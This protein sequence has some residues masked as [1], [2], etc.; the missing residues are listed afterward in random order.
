MG[1]LALVGVMLCAG[2]VSLPCLAADGI[3]SMGMNLAGPADWNTELPFVDVFR[4]SRPWISQHQGKSWGQGPK[5]DMDEH[6]WVKRLDPGCWAE[7][8]LCTIDGGHYPGG[9][10][11]VLY[12]GKGKLDFWGAARAVQSEPGRSAIDVDSSKGAIFLRLMETDAS[13]YVRNIRVIM[14]GFEETYKAN[15]WHPAF[16]KR[17][18]GM[19]CL[20]FMDFMHTNGSKISTWAERPTPSDA[21]FS[22]KGVALEW[23]IDLSNR[24]KADPW[25]CMPH[26]ADDDFVLNFAAMV[27]KDLDPDLKVYVEYS[28]EVWNGQ[29]AQSRWAGEQGVKLGFAEKTWEGAWRFTAYRSVQIF[30]IWEKVFGGTDRLVRVL[31]SQAANPY[32]SE[33]VVEWQD[34]YKHADA[35]AIAPYISFN[36]SPQGKPSA[37]E[38]AEWTV[39]QVLDY[40]ENKSLPESIAWIKGSKAVADKY[41]LKPMTYEG[42]QHAV[43]VGGGENNEKLTKLLHAANA[44][45]RIEGIYERHFDAWQEAGGDMF[46]YFS[47]TSKWSK[48][49][50]W[51]LLQYYD[52]DPAHSPKYR[53]TMR[54]AAKWGNNMGEQVSSDVVE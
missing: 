51:G 22:S 54:R 50:S 14:P 7:T 34:A 6:G 21:T 42:G 35:L 3:A 19:A 17:W 48:W 11:T 39:D 38:V 30:E 5:L 18:Q 29:F 27:K 28:N 36:I 2:L 44:H 46:C 23:M 16:L 52:D 24:L 40:I 45:P 33:R 43:G 1:R 8:P 37:G 13:D 31:P 26:L 41:G 32:V 10:Y 20:R 47:S 4:M 9:R 25:F 15:P 53:A 49:G 12:D